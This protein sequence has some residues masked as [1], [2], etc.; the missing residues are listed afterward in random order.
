[1]AAT[2]NELRQCHRKIQDYEGMIHQIRQQSSHV[3]RSQPLANSTGQNIPVPQ[4][5]KPETVSEN[6]PDSSAPVFV[7]NTGSSHHSQQAPYQSPTDLMG[8]LPPPQYD[9]QQLRDIFQRQHH[10]REVAARKQKMLEELQQREYRQQEERRD[11]ERRGYD[12]EADRAL[13]E[14]EELWKQAEAEK[15]LRPGAM[16]T[17]A[18][19][20]PP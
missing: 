7:S 3:P 5:L 13:R 20:R 17:S 12:E 14:A 6:I 18:R 8:S 10:Y 15:R 16:S 19:H 4:H 11:M 2:E 9:E 1:M